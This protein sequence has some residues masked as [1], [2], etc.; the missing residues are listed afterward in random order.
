MSDID[1][2]ILSVLGDNYVYVVVLGGQAVV[3]DPGEASGVLDFVRARSLRLTHVLVTHHHSDHTGGVR[4]I[5]KETGAA[6]VGADDRRIPG[7]TMPVVDE[8]VFGAVGL[9]WRAVAVPGHTRSGMA[10]HCARLAAVFTGDTLFAGGCGRLFEGTAEQMW[11]SLRRLAS[12][13]PN[14]RVYCGHEYT[15]ENAEF[16]CHVAPDDPEYRARLERVRALRS[17]GRPTVPVTLE[18]ERHANV[19]L[20]APDTEAFAELRRRKDRF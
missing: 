13:P 2:N 10:F 15:L 17:A 5:A 6:V 1:V 4:T 20:R 19:F 14:T 9:E 8:Q 3:V 7:L 18:E 11:H 12:L 16:A